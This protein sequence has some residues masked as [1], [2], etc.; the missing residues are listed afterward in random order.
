MK[1]VL[2]PLMELPKGK[3]RA[4]DVKGRPLMVVHTSDGAVHAMWNRCPHYGATESMVTSDDP[5][6]YQIAEG[7]FVVRCPWH[8][9]EFDVESGRCPADGRITVRKFK[10]EIENGSI[11]VDM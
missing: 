6:Q 1:H 8:T 5:G 4:V 11:V 9:Y 2:F 3:M 7:R 10:I